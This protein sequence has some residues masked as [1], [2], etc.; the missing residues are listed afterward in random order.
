MRR[1]SALDAGLLFHAV[2]SRQMTIWLGGSIPWAA[3]KAMMADSRSLISV[4][5]LASFT[6]TLTLL[7][8]GRAMA[9]RMAM[10][11][12]TTISSISVNPRR[13]LPPFARGGRGGGAEWVCELVP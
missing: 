8:A 11:T 9:S 4:A 2:A 13:S 10:I 1:M 7:I 6:L 3:R 12:I 5:T